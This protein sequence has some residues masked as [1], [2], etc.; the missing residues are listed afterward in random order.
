MGVTTVTTVTGFP[1]ISFH[2][3]ARVADDRD[4]PV[5][6][7][8][9]VTPPSA[10]AQGRPGSAVAL[11]AIETAG[12]WS[13]VADRGDLRAASELQLLADECERLPQQLKR[14]PCWPTANAGRAR[15]RGVAR[16]RFF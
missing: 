3:R 1:I 14:G 9:V 4:K 16:A 2:A 7:V 12:P 11:I 13:F 15:A 10:P 8:T 6:L 5:T